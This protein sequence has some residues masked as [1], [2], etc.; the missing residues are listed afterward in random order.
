VKVFL[1][2]SANWC[3][4]KVYSFPC[5]RHS[6]AEIPLLYAHGLLVPLKN[7]LHVLPARFQLVPFVIFVCSTDR[8]LN[9]YG[10][11]SVT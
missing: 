2:F 8:D 5:G 9:Y 7:L 6:Y 4:L 3:F 10:D 11:N 1:Y